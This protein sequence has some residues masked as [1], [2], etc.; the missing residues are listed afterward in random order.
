MNEPLAALMVDGEHRAHP[1]RH[2]TARAERQ[3]ACR[4]ADAGLVAG[5]ATA[6]T[7][8]ATS[9]QEREAARM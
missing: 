7:P 3:R 9:G 5:F 1:H 6:I 2:D 8:V 4:A